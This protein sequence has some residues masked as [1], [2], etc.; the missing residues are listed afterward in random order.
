MRVRA[1]V[2]LHEP[3]G[4]RSASDRQDRFLN[5]RRRQPFPWNTHLG[6]GWR[7]AQ[8]RDIYRLTIVRLLRRSEIGL[9]ACRKDSARPCTAA[10][11]NRAP[12]KQGDRFWACQSVSCLTMRSGSF[13]ANSIAATQEGSEA[14]PSM[15]RPMA[16]STLTAATLNNGIACKLN[17]AVS[18]RVLYCSPLSNA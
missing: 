5:G 2:Q 3:E 16:T 6:L 13:R 14:Q 7:S 8:T 10:D 18:F 9:A 4:H 17:L 11:A 12:P 15:W 1:A